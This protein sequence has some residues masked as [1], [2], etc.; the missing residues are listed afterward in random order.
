MLGTKVSCLILALN[1]G[2][3]KN[4]DSCQYGGGD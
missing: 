3:M 1:E 4:L 2:G